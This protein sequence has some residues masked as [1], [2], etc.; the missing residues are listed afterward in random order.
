MGDIT[1]TDQDVSFLRLAVYRWENVISF[2]IPH[3]VFY[4]ICVGYLLSFIITRIY[5]SYYLNCLL[6]ILLLTDFSI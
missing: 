3:L 4:E 2:I 6:F 5:C 1:L